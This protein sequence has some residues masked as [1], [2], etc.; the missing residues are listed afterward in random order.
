MG[1][2]SAPAFLDSDGDGDVD[3]VV[4]NGE[5][6]LAYFEGDGSTSFKQHSGH[7]GPLAGFV[8]VNSAPPPLNLN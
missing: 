5:G 3:L 1:T 8:L 2:N 4:G 6:K 7:G